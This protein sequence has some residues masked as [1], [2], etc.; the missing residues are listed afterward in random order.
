MPAREYSKS[1]RPPRASLG[2]VLVRT[3]GEL[4]ITAGIVVLLFVV[5]VLYV[6][7]WETA[8][9][10]DK[11]NTQ[12]DQIWRTDPGPKP[13]VAEGEAFLR[14]YIPSIGKDYR[15]T[16][17]KGVGAESL[18]LGPGHY[19]ESALPGEPGN[20]GVAGHR[21]GR[22]AP[23]NDLDKLH[24]CDA[25][26]V[27]TGS[28]FYI[29]RVLPMREELDR[30]KTEQTYNHRCA[31][32]P[33]LRD[34]AKPGG[35]PYSETV[36]RRIVTPDRGDAVA[37]VPYKPGERLPKAQQAAL[38]TLTTCHPEYGNSERMIIHGVLAGQVAKS[39]GVA[40]YD[41]LLRQIGEA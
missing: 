20:F 16:I 26:I 30:W 35:G 28:A 37:P 36:G 32:V 21:I 12:L 29:Y 11:R 4:L 31:N 23:F 24:S 33:T 38:I 9:A 34:P 2:V 15:Y 5:Y 13:D 18:K 27:E 7:D 22:G 1:Q 40:D 14:L 17:Q 41:A 25:I 6:T 39:S 3:L 10:Q 19:T 8:R